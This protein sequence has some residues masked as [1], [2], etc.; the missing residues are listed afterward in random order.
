[1]H[2]PCSNLA[3]SAAIAPSDLKA[4]RETGLCW[5]CRRRWQMKG[6]PTGGYIPSDALR[7]IA[8]QTLTQ[9]NPTKDELRNAVR[10]AR[11]V[12]HREGSWGDRPIYSYNMLMARPRIAASRRLPH[13][14]VG[15]RKPPDAVS[16]TVA[17]IHYHLAV[18]HLGVGTRYARW[19]CGASFML[20][21]NLIRPTGDTGSLKGREVR[22]NYRLEHSDFEVIGTH[23]LKTAKALGVT[24]EVGQTA[25][26]IYLQGVEDGTFHR[27]VI[28]PRNSQPTQGPGD[29]PFDH[30]LPD[31]VPW[32]PQ[33]GH[34]LRRASGKINGQWPEGVDAP[35]DER[36][37]NRLHRAAVRAWKAP[38][39]TPQPSATD[40][41]FKQP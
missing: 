11:G 14:L 33:H 25:T 4:R 3:C 21:R 8:K 6:I 19:L 17:A 12:R 10:L 34:G 31:H 13:M 39:Y 15:R 7:A 37:P 18:N 27:S 1:M 28:V 9:I 5:L 35:A 36:T 26:V 30:Y 40:W 2:H 16:I 32:S 41:L 20:R 22:R 24:R 29:H 23:V 38:T